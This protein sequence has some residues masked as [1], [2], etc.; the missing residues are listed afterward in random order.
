MAPNETKLSIR[1]PAVY[2]PP[3]LHEYDAIATYRHGSWRG[4]GF[5][6]STRRRNRPQ[7]DA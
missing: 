7:V 4:A 3:P 1:P 6:R 2:F 5:S